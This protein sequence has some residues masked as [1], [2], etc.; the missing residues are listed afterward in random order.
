MADRHEPEPF[1]PWEV[2]PAD[3]C[4]LCGAAV[5]PDPFAPRHLHVE[6]CR[7]GH[8]LERTRYGELREM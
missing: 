2:R 6:T 3:P 7:R 1:D 5:E 4:P 8:V